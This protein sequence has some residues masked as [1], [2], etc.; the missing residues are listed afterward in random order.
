MTE[1]AILVL[2]GLLAGTL[3]G[4]FG[5]GGGVVFIPALVF[6]A[7]L[8]Q[9]HAQASSL[10]AMLPVVLIGAWRQAKYGNVR[11]RV[12]GAIGLVSVGGVAAGA[13]VATEL[14]EHILRKLFAAFLFFVALRLVLSIKRMD[15]DSPGG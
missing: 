4:M 12:A 8:T 9:L 2:A 15:A 14:P 3:S 10:G 1:I 6:A 5:I 11:W 7:G 13:A